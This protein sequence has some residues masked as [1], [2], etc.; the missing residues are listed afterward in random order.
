MI[1]VYTC[2]S[3]I[4]CIATMSL[5]YLFSM[6]HK[7]VPF[8]VHI[9]YQLRIENMNAKQLLGLLNIFFLRSAVPE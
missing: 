8:Q 9:A 5:M 4:V 3:Y 2:A 7:D 6:I 1:R